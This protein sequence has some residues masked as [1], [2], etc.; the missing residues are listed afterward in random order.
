[1]ET[2]RHFA[3]APERDTRLGF[4]VR[5]TGHFQLIPPDREVMRT[6]DFCEIFWAVK[7]SGLFRLDGN[8]FILRPGCVWYYPAGSFHD[9][10]P[11]EPAFQYY[12]LTIAGPRAASFFDGLNIRPGINYGG[13]APVHLLSIIRQKLPERTREAKMQCLV[14]AFEILTGVTGDPPVKPERK[15]ILE[16]ARALCD[17]RFSDPQFNVEQAAQM[18]GIHRGSLSRIFSSGYGISISHYITGCR[19]QRAMHLLRESAL[20]VSDVARQSGFASPAYFAHVFAEHTGSTPGLFR[21][22]AEERETE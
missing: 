13:D 8:D 18:L 7:G 16:S 21:R 2:F 20:P 14:S 1:M 17:E 11:R 5:S 6:V 10:F 19:I 12:F 22:H 3:I 9:Y 4:H 15:G